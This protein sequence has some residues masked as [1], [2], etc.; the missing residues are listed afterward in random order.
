MA[1]EEQPGTELDED[2]PQTLEEAARQELAMLWSDLDT[3][4]RTGINTTWSI[5]CDGLADR[6][7]TLTRFVG[8]TPWDQVSMYLV[9]DGTYQRLHEEMGVHVEVDIERLAK[10]WEFHQAR[11]NRAREGHDR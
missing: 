5:R 8:P 6:I 2:E 3:A 10:S 9:K 7:K 4:I 11:L 1:A